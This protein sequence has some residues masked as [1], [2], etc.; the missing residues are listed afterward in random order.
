MDPGMGAV[1]ITGT[2]KVK[3]S[4]SSWVNS[5]KSWTGSPALFLYLQ[6][7]MKRRKLA[8]WNFG[9]WSVLP[10]FLNYRLLR[11]SS[12]IR[13]ICLALVI[14][15]NCSALSSSLFIPMYN[16]WR[17]CLKSPMVCILVSGWFLIGSGVL[18]VDIPELVGYVVLMYVWSAY[19][20]LVRS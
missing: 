18:Y 11:T 15:S 16:I 3:V 5:W 7:S 13:S 19:V 17:T 6:Y 8:I 1:T 10:P 4:M 14:P 9:N 12:I 2:S 20:W